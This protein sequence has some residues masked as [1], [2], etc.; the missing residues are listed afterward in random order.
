MDVTMD[1]SLKI[2]KNSSDKNHWRAVY[3]ATKVRK[4][5]SELRVTAMKFNGTVV[6]ISC[7]SQA[8]NLEKQLEA[9]LK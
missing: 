1:Y 2:V 3:Y 6:G 7:N 5:I 9:A 8:N 4:Q